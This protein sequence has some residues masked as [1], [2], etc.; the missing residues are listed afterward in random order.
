MLVTWTIS[1]GPQDVLAWLLVAVGVVALLYI[2]WDLLRRRRQP[3]RPSARWYLP[4]LM[5]GMGQVLRG[6]GQEELAWL[7]YAPAL[8]LCWLWAWREYRRR[9]Q[10]PSV[11]APPGRAEEWLGRWLLRLAPFC[12]AAVSLLALTLTLVRDTPVGISHLFWI[13]AP[14]AVALAL[15]FDSAISRQE[16]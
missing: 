2:P 16:W 1:L 10:R 7:L 8:T 13:V 12:L 4:I 6:L 9:P 11:P 3:S 5:L 14:L 15:W